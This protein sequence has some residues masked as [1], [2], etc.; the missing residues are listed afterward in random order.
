VGART[1]LLPQIKA[2]LGPQFQQVV[3][4]LSGGPRPGAEGALWIYQDLLLSFAP[5]GPTVAQNLDTRYT[6][7]TPV[8]INPIV[9]R[10]APISPAERN[11]MALNEI[12]RITGKPRVPVLSLHNIGDLFVPL[13]MEQIYA[14]AVAEH[15]QSHLLVQRAIRSVLHCDFTPTEASTAWNDLRAWVESGIRPAGDD[16][17]DLSSVASPAFGCRFTD[18]AVSRPFYEGESCVSR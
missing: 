17:L 5:G 3:T 15:G 16:F 1:A 2:K 4:H 18:P 6:P 10:V 14:R 11:S 7:R 8:D 13:S 9:E 12:P